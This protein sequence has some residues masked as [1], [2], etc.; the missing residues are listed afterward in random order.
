MVLGLMVLVS[1]AFCTDQL[2]EEDNVEIL[3]AHNTLRGKVDP[4]ATNME[5]LVSASQ[6]RNVIIASLMLHFHL[7]LILCIIIIISL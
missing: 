3:R 1:T 6:N 7:L 4:I 5:M 2:T